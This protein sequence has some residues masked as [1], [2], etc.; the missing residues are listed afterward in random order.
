MIR[1]CVS[2]PVLSVHN[3]FMAPKFW[4]A[5]RRLTMTFLRDIAIAPLA[6]EM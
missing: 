5:L 1:S 2:V 4:I 3:T 6:G